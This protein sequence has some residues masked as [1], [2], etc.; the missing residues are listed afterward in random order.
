MFGF[1]DKLLNRLA[2]VTNLFT[3]NFMEERF[4]PV[5]VGVRNETLGHRRRFTDMNAGY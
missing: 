2:S 1:E 4:W 5:H 3:A